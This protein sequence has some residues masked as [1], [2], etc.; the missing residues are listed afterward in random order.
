[1][2][3][4]LFYPLLSFLEKKTKPR[5]LRNIPNNLKSEQLGL[6]NL[7]MI[8]PNYSVNIALKSNEATHTALG[9]VS[10]LFANQTAF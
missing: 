4:A 6:T 5:G 2:L 3:L 7:K 9:L 1:M 8:G 10:E